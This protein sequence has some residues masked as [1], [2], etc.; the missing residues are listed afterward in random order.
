MT[1]ADIKAFWEWF[2]ANERLII[3]KV[4][5]FDHDWLRTELTRRVKWLSPAGVI[6]WEIGPGKARP[7]QFV[8][9]P[10]VTENL[11]FTEAAI[12]A[13]PDLDDWEWH[14]WKPANSATATSLS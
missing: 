7:W 13:A 2:R 9:S 6:N 12:R 1:T 3:E 11:E 8:L 14:A 4:K 10:V 5:Q